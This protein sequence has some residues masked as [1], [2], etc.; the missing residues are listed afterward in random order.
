MT[1]SSWP[2]REDSQ[3]VLVV[4]DMQRDFIAPESPLGCGT[5]GLSTVAAVSQ[6]LATARSSGIPIVYTKALVRPDLSDHGLWKN[7]GQEP[8]VV[9]GTTG[10]EIVP[11]IIPQAG[12][13]VVLKRRPSAFFCT[14]L[15]I[16][17][18]R[19][20]A[21]TLIVVGTT[22]SGCVRATVVD[23]FSRDF[24]VIV[25]PECVADRDMDVL[26]SNLRDV[27]SKYAS[28]VPL[29]HL[30]R[31]MQIYYLKVADERLE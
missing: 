19:L 1:A 28:V 12:D 24:H 6:L 15:D 22:M 18:R 27:E 30:I 20:D 3:A 5:I 8:R 14:D 29:E 13:F 17:L 2:S 11:E 31:T 4:I 9:E 16:I 21:D 26:T 7:G 23:A 10:A 25:P